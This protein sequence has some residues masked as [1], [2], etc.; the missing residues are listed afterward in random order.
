[1]KLWIGNLATGTTAEKV[2]RLLEK[3]GLPQPD[4]MLFLDGTSPGVL[5]DFRTD[6]EQKLRALAWRIEGLYWE[7]SRITVSPLHFF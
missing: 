5:A 1:M 7:G 4:H 6:D 2:A 3:Y